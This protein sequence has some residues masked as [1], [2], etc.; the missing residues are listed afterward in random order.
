MVPLSSPSGLSWWPAPAKINLF[1]HIV[2]RRADGYHLLQTAFQFLD[3]SDQLAFVVR[4]DGAIH[5]HGELSDV[6]QTDDL[7]VRAATALQ[8]YTGCALGVDIYLQKH[9]PMGGGIGGGSSD[10][11]TTLL[12]LNHYWQTGL[13]AE[14]LAELGLLLGADVPV[15]IH[16]HAAFAEGV[17]EKLRRI[18]PPEP[19]ML[20]VHPGCHVSTAQ[21]F[22]D[23]E[24]T[25][26]TE[27][28]TISALIDG[29][30]QNDCETVVRKHYPNV[31]E[32]IELLEE[33]G[34][35]KMTGT[36]ACVFMPVVN[37]SAGKQIILDLPAQY[38]HNAACVRSLNVSPALQLLQALQT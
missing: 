3:W 17:G 27:V 8:T 32:V 35:P 6:S 7:I 16:G 38:R 5:R 12:A 20:I 19:W 10:A 34:A 9:L 15:F 14:E 22:N 36:G 13:S 11:A 31:N 30:S 23:E 1:L 24:L 28:K 26:D 25:R 4:D 21:I 33:F 29:H 18:S 37:Q 2:G